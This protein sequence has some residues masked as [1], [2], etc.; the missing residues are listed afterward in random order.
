[1]LTP[2]DHILAF[3]LIVIVPLSAV[4]SFRRLKARR[5]RRLA[6]GL[7]VDNSTEYRWTMAQQ[8]GLTAVMLGTWLW[9][10]YPWRD[11]GVTMPPDRSMWAGW[12]FALMATLTAVAI[13]L[14]I[15][16]AQMIHRSAASRE[17]VRSQIA[18]VRDLLPSTPREL[19]WFTAL[20]ITA[21]IC[22]ELLYR[23][24][25]IWYL[26]HAM[27]PWLA[28][29]L[30]SVIFGVAHAY[31]GAGGVI[32]T[33]AVSVIMAAIYLVSGSLWLPML[34]HAMVDILSGRMTFDALTRD[35]DAGTPAVAAAQIHPSP[36]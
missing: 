11:L 12:G 27:N 29:A 36:A 10:A 9:H 7:P 22:E 8:W 18:N 1:M 3:V 31:Q 4:L 6:Q 32:K 13:V 20:S 15:M 34:L 33:G 2:I 25:M 26:A 28:A 30:S 14:L 24:W 17:K 16:Q 5:A 19:R 35:A 21:G 23:G